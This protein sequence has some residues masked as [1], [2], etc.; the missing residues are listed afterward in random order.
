MG[1]K[2]KRKGDP[3]R[4]HKAFLWAAGTVAF[5]QENIL[6]LSSNVT[7]LLQTLLPQT[8]ERNCQNGHGPAGGGSACL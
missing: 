6:P 5:S 7:H 8:M 1:A 3:V 4:Q 2:G